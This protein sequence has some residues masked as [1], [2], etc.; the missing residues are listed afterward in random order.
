MIQKNMDGNSVLVDTN[1]IIDYDKGKDPL[2]K[3][4]F[5]TKKILV[6]STITVFEYYSAKQL[7]DKDFLEKADL[8][9]S[10]FKIQEVNSE[11]AKVAAYLNRRYNLY[12]K[13]GVNDIIIA[14]TSF[15][16]EIP[17][18]TKNKKHF[19]LIPNLKFASLK[20]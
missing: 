12:K 7:K 13:I 16:L 9:F 19:K 6:V 15:Y 3:K 11:I 10:Y 18:L 5:Q 20:I 14:A 2:L 17:L 4:Y 8:L 1:V